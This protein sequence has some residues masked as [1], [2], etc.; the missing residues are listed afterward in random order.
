MASKVKKVGNVISATQRQGRPSHGLGEFK[1]GSV[2]PLRFFEVAHQHQRH[3][4]IRKGGEVA[5]AIAGCFER[6]HRPLRETE[7]QVE[8]IEPM[9]GVREVRIEAREPVPI[10][11]ILKN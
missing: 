5:F 11:K 10:I 3:R 6:G 7:N 2:S 1:C 8:A 9:V 4:R